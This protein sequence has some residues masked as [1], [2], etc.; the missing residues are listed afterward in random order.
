MRTLLARGFAPLSFRLRGARLLFAF[1]TTEIESVLELRAAANLAPSPERRAAYLR[2]SLDEAR[3]A[4]ML[5]ERS[6]DLRRA[7]GKEPFGF[8]RS[9]VDDLFERLGAVR[10]L[11]Y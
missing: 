8:P 11:A 5:S 9:D 3:H 1:S 6:A 2:H 10:V 4:R 7:E